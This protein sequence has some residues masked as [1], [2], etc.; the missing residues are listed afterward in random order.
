MKTIW[1]SPQVEAGRAQGTQSCFLPDPPPTTPPSLGKPRHTSLKQKHPGSLVPLLCQRWP[2]RSGGGRT[3][4][5]PVLSVESQRWRRGGGRGS[6]SWWGQRR[7]AQHALLSA[8][9]PAMPCSAPARLT[10]ACPSGLHGQ[11]NKKA[12]KVCLSSHDKTAH[13]MLCNCNRQHRRSVLSAEVQL[14]HKALRAT[15]SAKGNYCVLG[16]EFPDLTTLLK[17]TRGLQK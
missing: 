2:S 4:R 13:V 1:F 8:P 9:A 17:Y 7:R 5:V 6:N 3:Q 15:G 12:W 11:F 14:F 16:V 10:G